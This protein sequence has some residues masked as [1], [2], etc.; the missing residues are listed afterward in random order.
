MWTLVNAKPFG[1]AEGLLLVRLMAI[2]GF[3]IKN[4]MLEKI[5]F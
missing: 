5:L 3:G 1:L 2:F 4:E